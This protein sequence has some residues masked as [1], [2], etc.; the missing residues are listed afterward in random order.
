MSKT[1]HEEQCDV[2]QWF[3]RT[4]PGVRMLAIPNG[5]ARS[6][7]QGAKLKAEGVSRGV[8]D[9]FIPAWGM[10][11]EMKRTDGGSLSEHQKGW[12]DYLTSIGH[13]HYVCHG[14]KNAKETIQAM[15]GIN[16]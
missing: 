10:W 13:T 9:L 6:L 1:E 3:R 7:S 11:I 16:E 12:R 2:V 14:F 8:P 5:G 15:G 4:Y